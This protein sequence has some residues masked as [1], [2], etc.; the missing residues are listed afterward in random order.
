MAYRNLVIENTAQLRLKNAQLVITT[1]KQHTVPLE[2]V[3]SILLENQQTT[4][5]IATLAKIAQ[6]GITV[7]VCDAKHTPCGILMPF[8]Q[9]CRCSGMLK[10]QESLTLS[11]QK[12]LWQQIIKAKIA[13][14]AQCLLLL[15]KK[16]PA[17]Y[18]TSLIKKVTSGDSK[19][20]EA[21]AA[22]YYFKH[23]FTDKFY[24]NDE[25]DVRNGFLNYGYAIIRGHLARLIANYGF[26]PMKGIHHKNEL[27]AYNLADDFIEPFRPVVDLYVARQKAWPALTTYH[28]RA[29]YNLL[30][31]EVVLQG[32]KFALAFAAEKM[33]QSFTSCCLQKTKNLL[34]PNLIELKQHVYE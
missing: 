15:E 10:A 14:Q 9:H 7:Y 25:E 6:T 29:L 12:Q 22:H 19:N 1:D 30:N 26:I 24:R 33:V 31:M 34:L 4:I 27:N 32:Q 11:C 20:I 13:N 23:L 28:K 21:L 16:Q 5:T 3:N 8:A 18:L 17:E 2:D